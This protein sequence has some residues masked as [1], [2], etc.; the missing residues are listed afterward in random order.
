MEITTLDRLMREL[1]EA[2]MP[3][4]FTKL[5]NVAETMR[6]FAVRAGLGLAAQNRCAKVRLRAERGLGEILLVELQPG[7]TRMVAPRARLSD[8]GVSRRLS[9]RSQKLGAIPLAMF[10]AYIRKVVDRG[11]ELLTRQLIL[12]AESRSQSE[13]NRR[14]VVGGRVDDLLVW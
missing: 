5:A 7:R 14:K 11:D 6:M 10:D 3:S 8:I 12:H 9:A 13:L 2:R 1:S 4:D